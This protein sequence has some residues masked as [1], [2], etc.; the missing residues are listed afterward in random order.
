MI[1][2]T[3][4][5]IVLKNGS[6]MCTE[7]ANRKIVTKI[8]VIIPKDVSCYSISFSICSFENH[9]VIKSFSRFGARCKTNITKLPINRTQF[10]IESQILPISVIETT[11][12]ESIPEFVAAG[13]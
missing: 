12:L 13:E 10:T 7:L 3:R 1:V 8:G 2:P 5:C 9:C 4:E 6:K 11:K